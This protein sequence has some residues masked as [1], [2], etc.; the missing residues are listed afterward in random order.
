MNF[1]W[2]TQMNNNKPNKTYFTI[3]YDKKGDIIEVEPPEG[4]TVQEFHEDK[5]FESGIN[6]VNK[7]DTTLVLSK[8]GNTPCCVKCG[9]TYYCWC[10]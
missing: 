4:K 8:K 7:L 1:G 10:V 6:G 3:Y 5:I 2:E 9:R